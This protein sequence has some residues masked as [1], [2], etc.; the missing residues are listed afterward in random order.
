MRRTL[1]FL[2]M[3]I[4]G[5]CGSWTPA[6]PRERQPGT[7]FP[8]MPPDFALSLAVLVPSASAEPGFPEPAWYLVEADGQLRAAPGDRGPTSP[9]PPY[10]RQ[11]THDEVARL[12]S[13]IR[14]AGL[15]PD[16][17][18]RQGQSSAVTTGV[19]DVPTVPIER[20]M[21]SLYVCAGGDRRGYLI[22]LASPEAAAGRV[23]AL[24]DELAR[25]SGLDAE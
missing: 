15:S 6:Q 13:T 8:G 19:S 3:A 9:L 23:R 4:L 17:R 11:L 16:D 21:A 24:A 5:G 25:A 14:A 1:T 22:D 7:E 2:A 10:R 12:W 20:P 18:E